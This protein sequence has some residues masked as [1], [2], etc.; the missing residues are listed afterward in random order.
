MAPVWISISKSIAPK[1]KT[2]V[3]CGKEFSAM[4]DPQGQLWTSGRSLRGELGHGNLEQVNAWKKVEFFDGIN[5]VDLDCGDN[6]L[7]VVDDQGRA[8][9]C[10]R[11][12]KGQLGLEDTTDRKSFKLIPHFDNVQ[13]VSCG[14]DFS[15]L[16]LESGQVYAMGN[17]DQG[18][19]G[20]SDCDHSSHPIK[21]EVS[22]ETITKISAGANHSLLLAKSCKPY[23]MGDSS[24]GQLGL[25]ITTDLADPQWVGGFRNVKDISA[26]DGYSFFVTSIYEVWSFG[27]NDQGQLGLGHRNNRN[28]PNKVKG[29][30]AVSCKA[31][32]GKYSLLVDVNHNLLAC[33]SNSSGQHGDSIKEARNG[34]VK[35]GDYSKIYGIAAGFN[36]SLMI[37][38]NEEV[39]GSGANLR[40]QLGLGNNNP[41]SEFTL[42]SLP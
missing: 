15:L 3:S 35:I 6:F 29:V 17:N 11:N 26:G 20:S 42:I 19:L 40:G 7:I 5:L 39:L 31:S 36:H 30:K 12:H 14:R 33:G 27:R 25:G 8:Y 2:K 10:G 9:G 16:L 37:L 24:W 1:T 18:Q 13:S 32:F 38:S 21:V 22:G 4:I 28:M 41:Q 34:F 23:A